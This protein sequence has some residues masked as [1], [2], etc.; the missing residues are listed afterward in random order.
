MVVIRNSMFM[1]MT[2]SDAVL[3]L[4]PGMVTRHSY[5]PSPARSAAISGR[6][7]SGFLQRLPY[8]PC[9]HPDLRVLRVDPSL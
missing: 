4:M 5:V 8:P 2:S 3:G 6:S 9:K 7:L 1:P